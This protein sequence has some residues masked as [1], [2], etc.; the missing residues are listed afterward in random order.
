MSLFIVAIPTLTTPATTL[1]VEGLPI[2]FQSVMATVISP[3]FFDNSIVPFAF[4]RPWILD[5]SD[6]EFISPFTVLAHDRPTTLVVFSIM[7]LSIRERK[8][9]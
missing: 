3:P 6:E 2:A 8:F 9:P 5:T 4:S 1:A 7:S